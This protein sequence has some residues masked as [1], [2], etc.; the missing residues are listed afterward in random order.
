MILPVIVLHSVFKQGVLVLSITDINNMVVVLM[1]FVEIICNILDTI[2]VD[3]LESWG[4]KC[5]GDN[6]WCYISEV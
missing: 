3:F 5:H 2:P 4:R 6:I 1:F